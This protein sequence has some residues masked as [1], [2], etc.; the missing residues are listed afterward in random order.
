MTRFLSDNHHLSFVF[1]NSCKYKR[2]R[3]LFLNYESDGETSEAG[4]ATLRIA[5]MFIDDTLD[6]SGK[7]GAVSRRCSRG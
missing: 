7:T 4:N 5:K 6:F 2:V 3:T 1:F